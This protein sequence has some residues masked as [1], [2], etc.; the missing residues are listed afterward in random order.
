MPIIPRY[1]HCAGLLFP[2][3]ILS[4][5]TRG[6]P[7]SALGCIAVLVAIVSQTSAHDIKNC[8]CE[9]RCFTKEVTHQGCERGKARFS[10]N[11]LPAEDH[12]RMKGITA[13]NQQFPR[14]H[15]YH[16]EIEQNP[17]LARSPTTTEA[18]PI[19]VAVNGVPIFDPST[20]GP[21]N[22]TTGRR[23]NALEEGELDVCGGH[24]GRGDDYHYH[25]APKCLIEQ[26]G[27]KWIDADK[28]PVGYAMDG[29][30]ILALGWFNPVNAVETDLDQCRGM[31][32]D[33]G[34]YFYN[35]RTG[36]SYDVLTC[37][38]GTPRGFAKDRWQARRD[39]T[40]REITGIPIRFS[41]SSETRT[42][43]GQGIC[44]TMTGTLSGEQILV[45]RGETRKVRAEQGSLF[46]CNSGCYGLFFEADGDRSIRGRAIYYDLAVRECPAGFALEDLKPFAAYDGPTQ[47]RKGPA[48][49]GK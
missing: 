37:L 1:F 44:S 11:G 16:F 5:V 45:A 35:V 36:G 18:G 3:A 24:A 8:R 33:N 30:P 39:R 13:S 12:V 25:M 47:K 49:V 17:K 27:Q 31:A 40:G 23:P 20:Q 19:G 9:A 14:R 21:V 28:K 26:L 10:A 32:D 42:R 22:R 15:E 48:G 29:F 41:V 2:G 34:D 6:R 43:V 4:L 38:A 7:S 46:Y